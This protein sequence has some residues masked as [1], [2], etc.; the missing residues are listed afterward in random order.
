M[1]N[2]V[3]NG[4]VLNSKQNEKIYKYKICVFVGN[5]CDV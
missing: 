5:G 2:F 4:L 3:G 1:C